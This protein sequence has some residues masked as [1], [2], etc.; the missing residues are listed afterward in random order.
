MS[1]DLVYDEIVDKYDIVVAEDDKDLRRIIKFN[2]ENANFAVRE[3]ENGQIALDRVYE[4][5]PDCLI[6]DVM[7]PKMDGFEVC[8]RVKSVDSTR[9]IPIIFLTAR[10]SS[11][12]KVKG[13][14][15]DPDDYLT[16]PF[17]FPEL[18][19][20]INLHISKRN[21]KQRDVETAGEDNL[22]EIVADLS[23]KMDE[24]MGKLRADL[25]ML[26]DKLGGDPEL[27]AIVKRC[28]NS[29][30][31]LRKIYTELHSK[32]DPFY[33]PEEEEITV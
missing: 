18:I 30:R 10:G 21:A 6:L 19:A 4:K 31:E 24:P 2:L 5:N 27:S 25:E 22:T 29:R 9:D 20:R 8:K 16:K 11:E 13:M 15:F 1:D 26:M 28:E 12:D 17:D 7:M 23:S 3:A 14:G 32:L 33:E